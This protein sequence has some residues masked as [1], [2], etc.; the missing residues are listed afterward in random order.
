MARVE[1]T[2]AAARGGATLLPRMDVLAEEEETTRAMAEEA[3]AKDMVESGARQSG[4]GASTGPEGKAT[5]E[6]TLL[7]WSAEGADRFVRYFAPGTS[8]GCGSAAQRQ[9]AS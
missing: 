3:T 2:G 1:R 6:G 7:G 9:Q 4:T 8:P 5:R